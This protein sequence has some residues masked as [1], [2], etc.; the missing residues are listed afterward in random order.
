LGVIAVVVGVMVTN[1]I[2]VM[3]VPT[4]VLVLGSSPVVVVSLHACVHAHWWW[5]HR[6]VHAVVVTGVGVIAV[7]AVDDDT[8]GGGLSHCSMRAGT[9]S[10][11]SPVMVVVALQHWCWGHGGGHITACV[12][13]HWPWCRCRHASGGGCIVAY[14]RV[15]GLTLG[16]SLSSP[17]W[18]WWWLQ[19]SVRECMQ[20]YIGPVLVVSK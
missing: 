9:G 8:G 1:T 5:S 11:S 16:L 15:C 7:V 10:L 4:L 12:R 3:E 2:V 19:H 20:V 17:C 13:A 14:V 18:W 6:C